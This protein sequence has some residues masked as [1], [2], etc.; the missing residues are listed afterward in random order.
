MSERPGSGVARVREGVVAAL[1]PLAVVRLKR[2]LR[3]Q[4]LT[5]HCEN[6]RRI[7]PQFERDGSDGA[8]VRRHVVAL[9]AVTTGDRPVE[10]AVLV[11]QLDG[12]PVVFEGFEFVDRSPADPPCRT[13]LRAQ[14]ERLFEFEQPIEERVVRP[15]GDHR[16]RAFVVPVVVIPDRLAEVLD[17]PFCHLRAEIVDRVEGA[18]RI[19]NVGVVVGYVHYRAF[20]SGIEKPTVIG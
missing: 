20:G 3:H 19:P 11:D 5:P 6:R 13:G 16:I 8:D 1:D 12:E 17:L 9:G 4:H 18:R 14:I 7:A 2:R 15:I 10:F